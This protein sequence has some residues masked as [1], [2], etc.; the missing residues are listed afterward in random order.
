[1]EYT[2]CHCLLALGFCV[3]SVA[4]QK[5]GSCY[6]LGTVIAMASRPRQPGWS[7]SVGLIPIAIF[8]LQPAPTNAQSR[9]NIVLVMADDQGW[10]ET[11]YNGHPYLKTPVLDEM[12]VQGL[13]F[14]RFYSAAPNCSPTRASI[15]TG[16]HPNR[17]GVFAPNHSTRPEEIS[18]AQILRA[19]GYRTGH[20]GKW[21]VGAVKAASPTNPARMGYEEY[22]AHDNFFELDPPLSRNGKDPEIILGESSQICV[23]AAVDFLRSVRSDGPEP[24]F[25]TLWF[26]SPHSP[27]RALS[28]DAALYRNVPGE[29]LAN[30]FA[31]ITAMDRALGDFRSALREMG[32]A[33]NTLLWFT[34]D[35]GITMEGIP[36]DQRAA[37]YNG[38]WRGHKGSLYE[39][40]LR[41]PGI[42]EWP[43][44]I[45]E[46]RR[47]EMPVVSTDIFVT[48]LA[49]L[50]LRHPD[51]GRPL[52]GLDLTPLI[53]EGSMEERPAPIAFWSY[54][55]RSESDNPRWMAPSLTR[56]T[57]PTVRNPGIDF[58]NFRRPVARMSDFGGMAA[59]MENRYKL[60]RF[61]DQEPELYDLISDP[62]ELVDLASKQPDRVRA[63][64]ER[65]EEWQRSVERSLSG[66]DY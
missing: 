10:G 3:G 24:F 1:M 50:N 64:L 9:P 29:E 21:H 15:L 46:P 30:R 26:G 44:V 39:G 49:L 13:R 57:T 62:Q 60:V 28:D 45:R 16:R 5:L 42:I 19:A 40:G 56:G 48:L 27:Y 53:V 8:L 58:V 17:S 25:V 2:C 23:N 63:M 22:L 51:P 54:D 41:V 43:S 47:T 52:D 12:A 7:V 4:H 35:N 34:S 65:L 37:L 18:I 11:G 6:R 38:G 14:D 61:G 66:R 31:E 36:E 55:R 33:A 59:W 20:F 32:E